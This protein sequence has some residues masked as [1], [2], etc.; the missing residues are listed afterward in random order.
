MSIALNP[1][2]AADP[3][4]LYPD[5]NGVYDLVYQE[6]KTTGMNPVLLDDLFAVTT[7][8]PDCNYVVWMMNSEEVVGGNP[9][10][11]TCMSD[12]C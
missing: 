7:D 12:L 5:P 4:R 8:L 6:T 2:N 10:T 1:S 3:S 9:M 11:D